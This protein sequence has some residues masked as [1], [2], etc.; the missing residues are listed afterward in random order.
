[1]HRFS[2]AWS[3]G[4]DLS[5]VEAV[6]ADATAASTLRQQ[7]RSLPLGRFRYRRLDQVL[8]DRM[9]GIRDLRVADR[10]RPCVVAGP[11]LAVGRHDQQLL[12]AFEPLGVESC[13]RVVST[14]LP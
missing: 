2:P 1:M 11:R 10:G 14:T 12:G 5:N 8:R 13:R 6:V 3:I 7:D 9:T 4:V